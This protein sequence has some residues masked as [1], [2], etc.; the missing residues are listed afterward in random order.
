MRLT[1]T[2]TRTCTHRPIQPLIHPQPP[3]QITKSMKMI[4][5]TRLNKAQAGE[6]LVPLYRSRRPPGFLRE[7]CACSGGGRWS[8]VQA[9]ER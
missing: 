4:A 3:L 6:F 9:S 2:R 7:S 1:R 5:T 8:S